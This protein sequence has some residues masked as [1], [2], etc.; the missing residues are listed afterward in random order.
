MRKL[1]RE[2]GVPIGGDNY[3]TLVTDGPLFKKR[4][5]LL[6]TKTTSR[7]DCLVLDITKAELVEKTN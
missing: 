7:N 6:Q 3:H 4:L 5:R 1:H 2:Q